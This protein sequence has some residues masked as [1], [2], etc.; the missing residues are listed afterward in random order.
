MVW[1]LNLTVHVMN[2]QMKI[3][4]KKNRRR[5]RRA[6]AIIKDLQLRSLSGEKGRQPEKTNRILQK[7]E[8]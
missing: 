7:E 3:E 8:N 5:Q 2:M 1:L 4:E 6:K